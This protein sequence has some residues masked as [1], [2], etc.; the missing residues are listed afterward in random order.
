M[1]DTPFATRIEELDTPQLLLDLDILDANLERM[2][3]LFAAR[4]AR[5]LQVAQVR[6]AG[7]LSCR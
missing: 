6:L 2:R 3:K 1:P 4:S 7:A 5:S